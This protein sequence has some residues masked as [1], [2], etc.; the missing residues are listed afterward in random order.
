[1]ADPTK[2][3]SWAFMDHIAIPIVNN[4]PFILV[5]QLRMSQ[6]LHHSPKNVQVFFMPHSLTGLHLSF[7]LL[8]SS[9]LLILVV[10]FQIPLLASYRAH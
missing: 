9:S 10:K 6:H 3:R 4:F 1:M 5:L 2:N 7:N 8:Y